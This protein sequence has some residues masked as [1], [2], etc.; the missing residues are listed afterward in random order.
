[1]AFRPHSKQGALLAGEPHSLSGHPA[2][3]VSTRPGRTPS[4]DVQLHLSHHSS[5]SVSA[6]GADL[7][8]CSHS[9]SHT[10]HTIFREP[11]SSGNAGGAA[12]D[13]LA[14]GFGA[15]RMMV[16]ILAR[17]AVLERS[18]F[19]GIWDTLREG[20]NQI[21]LTTQHRPR[22]CDLDCLRQQL[23]GGTREV[24]RRRRRQWGF[25]GDEA[26][27]RK[28]FRAASKAVVAQARATQS[29]TFIQAMPLV[30]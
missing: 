22:L 11:F 19:Q 1:M 26:L 13:Q 30:T 27:F 16:K 2:A 23:P 4:L 3:E 18:I 14:R 9:G 6:P 29:K 21:P 17:E 28:A 10:S 20:Q 12:R 24:S 25:C 5:A 15:P 7:S 8:G